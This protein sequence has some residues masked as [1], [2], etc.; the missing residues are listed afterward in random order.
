[1]PLDRR[2][3]WRIVRVIVIGAVLALAL[4]SWWGMRAAGLPPGTF[5]SDAGVE[6]VRAT[7]TIDFRPRPDDP[8]R[9]GLIFFPN[10]LV[11]PEAYAPMARR[12]AELGH[13]VVIIKLPFRLA[14]T[15]A[16][17]RMVFETAR[18]TLTATPRPWVIAGHSRGGKFAAEFVLE[19]PPASV[20]GLAL[21]GTTHPRDRNLSGLPA[22]LPV[23]RISG[24]RDGIAPPSGIEAF[25]GNVPAH[26]RSVVIEGGNNAQFAYYRFQPLDRSATIDRAS[27]QQKLIEALLT[28]LRPQPAPADQSQPGRFGFPCAAEP[29]R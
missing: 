9:A 24:T 13:H 12:L 11:A 4:V 10:I 20:A 22:C 23:L 26:T 27:Q 28:I 8:A 16:Y 21:I 19:Q 3:V 14:P 1:M 5:A 2:R 7:D 25:R 18:G 15:H 17:H 6:I 29:V